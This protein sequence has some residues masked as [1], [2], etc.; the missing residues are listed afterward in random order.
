MSF[1]DS[2]GYVE[3]REERITEELLPIVSLVLQDMIGE[4]GSPRL[5]LFLEVCLL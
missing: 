5:I 2:K 1:P 3:E 4:P